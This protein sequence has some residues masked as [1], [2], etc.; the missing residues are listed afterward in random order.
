MKKILLL[1]SCGLF[2]M[3]VFAQDGPITDTTVTSG[4]SSSKS[5]VN[6]SAK[7]NDHFL[8]QLGYAGWNGK[9]DTINTTGLPRAFN[10][11]LMFDFPFKTNPKLSVAIGPGIS[12]EHIYFSKTRIG[13]ADRTT[14]LSFKNVSDTSYFKKYKLATA[15]LEA[16]I[17]LRFRSNPDNP[18]KGYKAAIGIK[19]GTL[20]NAHTKGKNLRTTD[21]AVLPYTEKIISKKYFNTTRF[22]A[23]ARFGWGH[24]SLYGS[25]QLNSLFKEGVAPDVRPFQIGLTLSGL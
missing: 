3:N 17:E 23:T 21:G 4:N 1:L 10:M 18:N 5:K 19:V 8:L 7:A 13:L 20:L 11:Y 6:F 16:P 9:P 14:N 2:A 15:W 25:Y 24:Y 12:T 22:S